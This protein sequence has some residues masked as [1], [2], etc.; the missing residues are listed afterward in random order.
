MLCVCS[1][2]PVPLLLLGKLQMLLP[3]LLIPEKWGQKLPLD[4]QQV[5]AAAAA[6]GDAGFILQ[7]M[8]CSC[9]A[10]GH[11]GARWPNSCAEGRV[12]VQASRTVWCRAVAKSESKSAWERF[13]LPDAVS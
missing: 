5:P 12:G 10:W 11:M 4:L 3:R 1:V 13:G 2:L 8:N 6:Q 7:V 9:C